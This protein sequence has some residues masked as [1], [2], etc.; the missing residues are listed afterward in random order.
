MLDLTGQLA[1]GTFLFTLGLAV[2]YLIRASISR[3]RRQFGA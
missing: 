1:I 2:G 3:N